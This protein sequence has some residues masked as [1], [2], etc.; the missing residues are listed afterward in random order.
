MDL[1]S[2]LHRFDNNNN[3]KLLIFTFKVINE[4]FGKTTVYNIDRSQHL[5]VEA[6]SLISHDSAE[7]HIVYQL[8]GELLT[9]S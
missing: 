5:V 3:T 4:Y 1:S 9:V 2:L 6:L 7:K 8:L